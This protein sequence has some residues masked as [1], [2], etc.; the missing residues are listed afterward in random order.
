M[1]TVFLDR[2]SLDFGDL[3]MS[4]LSQAV[5]TLTCYASTEPAAVAERIGEAEIVIVNKVRLDEALMR[6][7]PAL[8]LICV[9]ATGTNNV[10]LEAA[11]RR[12][13]RVCNCQ[14]Y[15]TASV[16]QHVLTLVLALSTSLLRYHQAVQAGAWGRSRQFC[17]LDYPIM[18]L[19]GK[20]LGIVGYGELGQAV[21]RLAEAFGMRVLV[22]ARP[23][24]EPSAGRLALSELLPRVD[25][26]SLHCP[27]TE[28]TRDLIGEDQL[29]LLKPG[30]LLINAARGGVV[31]EPALLAALQHGRLGGAGVDVLSEEPPRNGNPLLDAKLPNLII[32]PHS[33]WGSCEARQ[34][35]VGQLTENIQAWMRGSP[36]RCVA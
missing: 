19:E 15:G 4:L 6:Q 36:Q 18:E 14:G 35:I 29:A 16:A 30:A 21:A 13:I 2:D 23:G 26:L 3:D 1:R 10:D 24:T 27:L 33:A 9:A 7:A 34:R 12:G 25:V 32:T 8:K 11:A 5:E 31:N 22:A 20:T 28:T 17:L